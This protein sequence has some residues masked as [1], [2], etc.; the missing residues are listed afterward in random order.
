MDDNSHDAMHQHRHEA[1]AYRRIELITGIRRRRRWTHE[2]KAEIVSASLRPGVNISDVARHYGVNR[3][4]L[5]TWRRAA[6]RDEMAF[7]PVRVMET[8]AGLG[9]EPAAGPGA[10][11][12]ELESRGLR[13]R[14]SG[15]VDPAALRLVLA[16]AGRRG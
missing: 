4:L 16:H 12:I 5:Q 9:T 10:G 6:A 3:G 14:F 8:T 13:V 11:V 2:E 15:P 7:I 1:D